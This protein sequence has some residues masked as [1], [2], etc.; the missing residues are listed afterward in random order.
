MTKTIE[1]FARQVIEADNRWYDARDAGDAKGAAI[2]SADLRKAY[3]DAEAAGYDERTVLDEVY[4]I[5][6]EEGTPSD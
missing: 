4:R 6:D 2:A 3:R 1:Q 5:D